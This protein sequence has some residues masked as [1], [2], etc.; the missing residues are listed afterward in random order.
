MALVTKTSL[1]RYVALFLLFTSVRDASTSVTHYSIS[2]EMKEGS[3]VANLA[4]DL[5]LDITTLTK[6]KMRVDIIANKKYLDVNKETGDL[7]VLEKI[8]REHIYVFLNWNTP[9]NIASL[10]GCLLC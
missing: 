1:R 2:E 9:L 10:D 5:G 7:Y 3:V 4:A 6:R 8:D